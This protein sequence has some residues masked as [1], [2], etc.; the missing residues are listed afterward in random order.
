VTDPRIVTS[1]RELLELGVDLIDIQ[2]FSLQADVD[3]ESEETQLPDNV[4]PSYSMRIRQEDDEIGVRLATRLYLGIGNVLVDV[5][6]TYK[7]VQPFSMP[8][9]ARLEFATEVG[10]M[11]LVPY[12]RQA[13]ADLTQ[14]VFGQAV[15][16][17]II[18]RGEIGF[19]K[20]EN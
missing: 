2:Y 8:E 13:V 19:Q 3:E 20:T 15:L 6:A 5:A 1:A 16:M 18:Q 14:R 10:I 4:E 9:Q 17:P 11:A 12:V 7:A